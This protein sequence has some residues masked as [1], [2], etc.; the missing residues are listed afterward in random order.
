M[1][2]LRNGQLRK[3]DS[4]AWSKLIICEHSS[5]TD[6]RTKMLEMRVVWNCVACDVYLK[7]TL[8]E[9]FLFFPFRLRYRPMWTIASLTL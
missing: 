3:K 6:T 7:G 4:A 2:W 9:P 1:G 5:H 8:F